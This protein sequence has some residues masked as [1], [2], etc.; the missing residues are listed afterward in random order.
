M[1]NIETYLDSLLEDIEEIDVSFKRLTSLDVTRFSKLK[2]LICQ[3]NQLTSLHLPENLQILYCSHNQLTCLRLNKKLHTMS[4]SNN[5]VYEFINIKNIYIN[6]QIKQ[7]LQVLNQ[8]RYL[9]YCLKFKKRFRDLLWVKIREPKIREKY[10]YDYLVENLH[11]D[12]DL[13]KLLENW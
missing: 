2:I 5:P 3:Y 7:K 11:D 4:C 13:D 1:F 6:Y 9:Y 8:F 12:T 10:S